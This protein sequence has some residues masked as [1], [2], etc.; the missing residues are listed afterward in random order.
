M[1]YYVL[2]H[3]AMFWIQLAVI[4]HLNASLCFVQISS[5]N[6]ATT[7]VPRTRF[8][9][10]SRRS[11]Q[12]S[13]QYWTPRLSASLFS[14][15]LSSSSIPYTVSIGKRSSNPAGCSLSLPFS[16]R[17]RLRS[18]GRRLP[19]GT[20]RSPNI[21]I[22]LPVRRTSSHLSD[23]PGTETSHWVWRLKTGQLRSELLWRTKR[24]RE[25]DFVTR[26]YVYKLRAD[27]G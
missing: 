2:Q 15:S 22:R 12:S 11:I 1:L 27:T 14:A 24:K 4:S 20:L 10:T 7:C 18:V 23:E 9:S 6:N 19:T 17:L 8:F 25:P 21:P 16:I 13:F 3:F 26:K 5:T